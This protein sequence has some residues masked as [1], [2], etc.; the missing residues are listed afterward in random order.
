MLPAWCG[1]ILL[2]TQ[3]EEAPGLCSLRGSVKKIFRSLREYDSVKL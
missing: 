3:N 1:N 2:F